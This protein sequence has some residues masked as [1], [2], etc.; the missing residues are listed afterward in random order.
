LALLR[1]LYHV[2]HF[3][4]DGF[5]VSWFARDANLAKIN[6][7]AQPSLQAVEDQELRARPQ[8]VAIRCEDKLLNAATEFG[9]IHALTGI[10]KQ[11]LEYQIAEVVILACQIRSA[12][13]TDSEWVVQKALKSR[14][15]LN[16]IAQFGSFLL[17]P[18]FTFVDRRLGVGG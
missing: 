1:C 4:R 2:D 13:A 11:D 8:R 14:V 7:V 12:E 6:S 5:F 18:V 9:Q 10:G 17:Y 16:W 15:G 3:D